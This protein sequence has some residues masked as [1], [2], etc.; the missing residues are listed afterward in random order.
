MDA[1]NKRHKFVQIA[2]K[3]T[4]NALQ[5]IRIIGNLSNKSNYEYTETDIRRI[6]KALEQEIKD[7]RTRFE[8]SGAKSRPEFKL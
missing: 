6:T 8:T 2:E 5:A 1:R 3:R 7:L 4:S